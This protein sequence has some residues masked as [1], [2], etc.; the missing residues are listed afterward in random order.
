MSG[1]MDNDSNDIDLDESVDNTVS[2]PDFVTPPNGLYR[3][4]VKSVKT[5]TKPDK[6]SLKS[7]RVV[8][9]SS[10]VLLRLS[11]LAMKLECRMVVS[12]V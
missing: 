4:Q 1:L 9:A 7:R 8:L 5:S 2:A 3:L 10:S 12:S 11:T 6:I